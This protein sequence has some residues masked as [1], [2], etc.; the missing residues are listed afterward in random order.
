MGI[1]SGSDNSLK[2][3]ATTPEFNYSDP[4]VENSFG[5]DLT[6][7]DGTKIATFTSVSGGAIETTVIGYTLNGADL[8]TLTGGSGG[9]LMPGAC[10]FEPITLSYGVT[11]DMRFWEWWTDLTAGKV[12]RRV[13][14]SLIAYGLLPKKDDGTYATKRRT[15]RWDLT[16]AWPS[17]VSGFNFDL[18]STSAFIAEVT[19]IVESITRVK[20]V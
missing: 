15:A 16:N 3:Q 20:P 1:T 4:Y 13:N 9:I 19:L 11:E 6:L 8:S 5:V 17:R 7:S 10:G 2:D 14:L 12:Y 18:D